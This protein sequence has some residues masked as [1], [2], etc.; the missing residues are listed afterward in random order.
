MEKWG[1]VLTTAGEGCMAYVSKEDYA[2]ACAAALCRPDLEPNCK[3]EVSGPEVIPFSRFVSLTSN[4][5]ETPLH[6]VQVR[7]SSLDGLYC[8]SF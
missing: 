7:A 2:L 5:L 3:F 4:V 1:F 8:M 6:M